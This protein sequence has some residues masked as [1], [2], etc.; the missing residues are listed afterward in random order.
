MFN[1]LQALL[2]NLEEKGTLCELMGDV[3]YFRRED[4]DYSSQDF[5]SSALLLFYVLFLFE[6]IISAPK[7]AC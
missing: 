5:A 3:S 6:E 4:A 1:I 7:R 2:R